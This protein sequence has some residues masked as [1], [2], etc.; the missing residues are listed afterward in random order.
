M[1]DTGASSSWR[2]NW[3]RIAISVVILG[4]IALA[5]LFELATPGH[6][7]RCP[8]LSEIYPVNGRTAWVGGCAGIYYTQDTGRSWSRV[9]RA[10]KVTPYYYTGPLYSA[11]IL[12]PGAMPRLNQSD[13]TRVT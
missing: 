12:C 2:V 8:T 5:F 13:T 1:S 10:T 9:A 11:P 7:M 6:R 3:I 4:P